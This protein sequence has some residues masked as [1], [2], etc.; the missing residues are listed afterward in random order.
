MLVLI[1]KKF[2]MS[3]Y[4]CIPFFL[5]ND[6]IVSIKNCTYLINLEIMYRP[7]IGILIY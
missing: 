5:G 4:K 7:S 1:R 6:L 3:Y 2:K